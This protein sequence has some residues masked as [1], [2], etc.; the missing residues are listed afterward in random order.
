M[1]KQRQKELEENIV[2][3]KNSSPN[4]G[5]ATPH[6]GRS[7]RKAKGKV[8]NQIGASFFKPV[9]G[10]LK[11]KGPGVVR[12]K[13]LKLPPFIECVDPEQYI[14]TLAE[15]GFLC[16]KFIIMEGKG[17]FIQKNNT[18]LDNKIVK[19]RTNFLNQLKKFNLLEGASMTGSDH[20]ASHGVGP[21]T[22]ALAP[23]LQT[24]LLHKEK[25]KGSNP[26]N[27]DTIFNPVT[28]VSYLIEDFDNKISDDSNNSLDFLKDLCSL[29]ESSHYLKQNLPFLT[30]E[31]YSQDRRQDFSKFIETYTTSE[32]QQLSNSLQPLKKQ[33][34]LH[35]IVLE[36]WTNGSLH[37]REALSMAFKNLASVFLNLQKTRL[38]SSL[39][40][41][42]SSY[43][44]NFIPFPSVGRGKGERGQS[45]QPPTPFGGRALPLEEKLASS[46]AKP[47]SLPAIEGP[48]QGEEEGTK[49]LMNKGI[50]ILNIPLRPYTLLKR[51]NI[52]KISDLC[53]LTID[54]LELIFTN[55][56]KR[57]IK[58]IVNVVKN[59]ICG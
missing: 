52:N 39:Y 14:A 23:L 13:D 29:I 19:N 20:L 17:Y 38:Y 21:A 42:E 33:S 40:I 15:D 48:G 8:A 32:I 47:P 22:E 46:E 3:T 1:Q 9:S 53:N 35:V 59:H 49:F 56:D 36:I 28:K 10:F 45:P 2:K 26:L 34:S 6:W 44:K 16:M 55:T 51:S 50:E 31:L 58:M 25:A 24:E 27:L 30:N 4:G 7:Q 11:I 41:N 37:P 12:A 5:E 18:Y 57:Y 54:D 43:Q